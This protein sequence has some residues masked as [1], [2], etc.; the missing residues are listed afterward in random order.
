MILGTCVACAQV[1]WGYEDERSAFRGLVWEAPLAH[2]DAPSY[3]ESVEAIFGAF[4]HRTGKQ[5]SPGER[6]RVGIK[7]YTNSG[8]GLRTPQ[9]L[10][11]AA[12]ESLERRGFQRG[13]IF[14]VD[15]RERALRDSGYLPLLSQRSEVGNNFH[16]VPVISLDTGR[17]Y[18]NRWYYDS[19]LPKEVINPLGR[20]VTPETDISVEDPEDRKSYLPEPLLTQ[21]DFWINLPVVTDH[22]SLG[23]NGAM[24]NATLWNVSNNS[25]FFVSSSNAPVAVAE[26]AAIPEMQDTW[27]LSIVS[28]QYYQFIG[29]PAF[30]HLYV[31]SQPR[32]LASVDP[33]VLDA[34]V[35]KEISDDRE[36]AGF[37]PLPRLMPQL[38]YAYELQL[39]EPLADRAKVFKL[40][41]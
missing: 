10:T 31:R 27:A 34:V 32:L 24:V 8:P 14:I 1:F 23:L 28:L 26:I 33:V 16:G 15:Q 12:I 41:P 21:V 11:L 35:A 30:N 20:V 38:D 6:R 3:E 40:K 2:F 36:S 9:A 29:G 25:R 4:E 5:L 13:E 39:G 17:Y 22:S 19:P 18:N 37:R 7:V